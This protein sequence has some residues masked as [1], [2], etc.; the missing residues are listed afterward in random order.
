MPSRITDAIRQKVIELRQA[1]HS[2]EEVV[3][4]T[5][6]S[7]ATI[8]RIMREARQRQAAERPARREP[9]PAPPPIVLVRSKA[10]PEPPSPPQ[11]PPQGPPTAQAI[12]DDAQVAILQALHTYGIEY[13]RFRMAV[14][15]RSI[16]PDE[17]LLRARE[18]Y[19]GAATLNQMARAWAAATGSTAVRLP[20]E[21]D[22]G[23]DPR[24][25]LVVEAAPPHDWDPEAT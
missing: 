3:R 1:G 9:P 19:L 8:T 5:G 21:A 12:A 10:P 20:T 25:E 11:P 14:M 23:G 22:D 13:L 24:I 16:S 7:S 2:V 4:M 15:D 17:A 6:V 18:F